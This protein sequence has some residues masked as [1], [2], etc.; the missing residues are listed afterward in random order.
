MERPIRIEIVTSEAHGQYWWRV[1]STAN[2]EVLCASELYRRRID[3]EN[4]AK[5]VTGLTE[6]V[7]VP[8]AH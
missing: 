1:V 5:L 8:P 6:V 3:A 7:R 4:T 2:G